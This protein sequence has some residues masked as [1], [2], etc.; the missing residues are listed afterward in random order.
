MTRIASE[1]I[2]IEKIV[3][4][5]EMQTMEKNKI[6][7]SEVMQKIKETLRAKEEY[8]TEN[9][10]VEMEAILSGEKELRSAI[11]EIR[12]GEVDKFVAYAK[13][14]GTKMPFDAMEMGI[15][16]AG[17]NDMQNGL[18]E[19]LDSMKFEQPKCPKC[20]E[21]LE[22]RGRSKKNNNERRRD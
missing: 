13:E 19:I 11:G 12:K 5:E 16:A 21:K 18:A 7:L 10:D 4:M 14:Q 20:N 22:N 1:I 2:M 6:E 3:I 17:R 15:V 8:K 9:P